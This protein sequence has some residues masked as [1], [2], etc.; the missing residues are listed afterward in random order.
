MTEITFSLDPTSLGQAITA[1]EHYRNRI[2]NKLSNAVAAIAWEG[3]KVATDAFRQVEE[4]V[5]PSNDSTN[6]QTRTVD[7]TSGPSNTV[8]V[9]SEKDG[10][11]KLVHY[12]RA[13]GPGVGFA[14]FGAGSLSDPSHPLV[15]NA[16]F[17][18]YPGS[19]SQQGQSKTFVRFGHW[20]YGNEIFYSIAPA[21]GLY[22]ASRTMAD[23]AEE[24]VK[25]EFQK[26]SST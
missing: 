22:R 17:P 11:D 24:I 19:W 13:Y 8:N 12:V 21:R 10:K 16:P 14:E 7:Y 6:L 1:L 20:W 15:A 23:K 3:E 2:E 9:E 5:A 4:T 26:G 25:D 18:V